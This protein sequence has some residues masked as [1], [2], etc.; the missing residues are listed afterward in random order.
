MAPSGAILLLDPRIGSRRTASEGR[1]TTA[2]R[3]CGVG[4]V[5]MPLLGC[6]G[7][8]AVVDALPR[9]PSFL[10]VTLDTTRAD[11]LSP[12]GGPPQLTPTASRLA[13]DGVVFERAYTVTPLTIPA[14]ASL[15]SGLLPPRHGVRDNGD[16]R[17][18]DDVVT[19][20]ERFSA[21]GWHTMASVGAEVTRSHW[22]FGQ[23]FDQYFDT[24]PAGTGGGRWRVER[25][26]AAVV[27]DAI[28]WLADTDGPFFAWVHLFDA[29]HPYVAPAPWSDQWADRPYLA[30]VAFADAQLG[31]L[32]AA[33][34]QQ[35]RLDNTWIVV[36][37]DHG[38]GL[39][40]HGERMHGVLLYDSTV[41]IPLIIRPPQGLPGPRRLR[42]PASIVDLAPTLEALAPLAPVPSDGVSFAPWLGLTA[43]AENIDRHAY[44]ES[45]YGW[46]HYGWAPQRAV[47][48]TQDK[49]VDGAPPA[50]F[51]A[52]DRGEQHDVAAA[53]PTDVQAALA[54]LR[55]MS[56]EGPSTAESVGLS[57]EQS[58]Q[59]AA[60]GYL[61]PTGDVMGTVPWDATLP[62]PISQLPLLA[63]VEDARGALQA[64]DS[65]T[66]RAVL[67]A[68]LAE[69]PGLVEPQRLRV[70]MDLAAG[71]TSAALARAEALVERSRGSGTLELLGT[72]L[73]HR[74]D[75]SGALQPLRA[76]V[77]LD[78]GYA[79]AWHGLLHAH[80]LLGDAVGLDLS[81]RRAAQHHPR[82]PLVMGMQGLVLALD[83]DTA[84]ARAA[85][86]A[87]LDADPVQP[88]LHY[89]LGVIALHE[90]AAVDAEARFRDELG[91]RPSFAPARR[92]LIGLL[93]EQRRYAEQL[94]ELEL[95]VAQLPRDVP[96]A[97]SR[98][99]AR[100][101]LGDIEGAA[102]EVDRCRTL[103]PRYPGCALLQANVLA[104]QGDMPGA[105]AAFAEAQDLAAELASSP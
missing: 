23:G 22:G 33:L 4:W 46:R 39:G 79:P 75:A 19:L 47:V 81:A 16:F 51:L 25:S 60:L 61:E 69:S 95:M 45:V 8:P 102:E 18:A 26:G 40:D 71:D 36:L 14:H 92:A 30:E 96:T 83:G 89:A 84:S 87:A 13:A 24:M 67:D 10:V 12:Y 27:D 54:V 31:R 2:P 77:E 72:V 34:E 21:A 98:A 17:L 85:M 73:L 52:A 55:G 41:R 3:R 68:L 43:P 58:A 56:V 6:S 50:L 103:S 9:P 7:S 100:F 35:G 20:A 38:E 1:V 49:L 78:P 5:L 70:Q 80:Y 11:V 101:N 48:R 105:K 32:V 93:A 57:A 91:N 104:K 15:H 94:Q 88:L 42:A 29:H 53:H 62:A 66:A 28:G 74:G 86:R 44:V 99:Q 97:H 82:D 64:G 76:A 63:R 90:G 59:L 37:S 65:D